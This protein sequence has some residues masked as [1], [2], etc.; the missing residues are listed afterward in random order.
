MIQF[1]QSILLV[2][3]FCKAN[4]IEYMFLN[5]HNNFSESYTNDIKFPD[6]KPTNSK[7]TEAWHVI[8]DKF[9]PN[10]WDEDNKIQFNDRPHIKWL[11]DL[12]NF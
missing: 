2:Q 6:W 8:Y 11:Y 10:T 7:N 5:M 1:L 12:I 3:S 9:I 4:G